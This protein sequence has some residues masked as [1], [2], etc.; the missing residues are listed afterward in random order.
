MAVEATF[1]KFNT[2][3]FFFQ[4]NTKLTHLIE[5]TWKL[6]TK[7]RSNRQLQPAGPQQQPDLILMTTDMDQ[8]ADHRIS[9]SL[10]EY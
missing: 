1:Q 6:K 9:F 8:I 5:P 10:T 4:V 3:L 7:G 2:H